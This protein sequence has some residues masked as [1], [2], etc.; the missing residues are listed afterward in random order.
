MY[1][2][3]QIV[4]DIID[5]GI[6]LW[7]VHLDKNVCVHYCVKCAVSQASVEWNIYD[8]KSEFCEHFINKV[9]CFAQ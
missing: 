8:S 4:A 3:Y 9:R 2:I 1:D 5:S 6:V 7:V